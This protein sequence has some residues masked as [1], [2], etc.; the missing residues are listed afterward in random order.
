MKL[1][2][3]NFVVRHLL[4]TKYGVLVFPSLSYTNM[5]IPTVLFVVLKCNKLLVRELHSTP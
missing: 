5:P 4:C 1:H 3:I 2:N